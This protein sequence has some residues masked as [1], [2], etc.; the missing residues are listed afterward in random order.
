MYTHF[1]NLGYTLLRPS[2]TVFSTLSGILHPIIRIDKMFAGPRKY[3]GVLG[4]DELV[5]NSANPL[6]DPARGQW[7]GTL[8]L[9]CP[10]AFPLTRHSLRVIYPSQTPNALLPYYHF[11]RR[12][13]CIRDSALCSSHP[14]C[15]HRPFGRYL[16]SIHVGACPPSQVR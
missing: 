3:S 7:R 11:P 12:F 13:S 16:F 10:L 6:G 4:A 2:S 5:Q 15:Y 1:I 14:R 9:N 8:K